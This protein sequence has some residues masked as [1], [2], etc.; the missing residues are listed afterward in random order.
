MDVGKLVGDSWSN[1][2][3]NIG[4]NIVVFLVG[5]IA[6]SVLGGLTLMILGIPI[7]A[8]MAKT[9]RKVANGGEAEMNDL[10][11][12]MGN[13]GKW[14][15]LWVVLLLVAIGSA[16]TFGIGGLVA[17]FTLFF[18]L[19]LMIDR[20]LAGMDAAKASFNYSK[21][22]L[23]LILVPILVF[24]LINLVG[25][26]VFGVGVLLTGPLVMIGTWLLYDQTCAKA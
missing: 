13:V 26:A 21:A 16:I 25:S 19:P 4:N 7:Y 8:G 2:S 5:T 17:A 23:G 22:N 24:T 15:S 14:I 3:R 10:F 11:A 6:A 18:T 9:F 20:G 12:E 1:F